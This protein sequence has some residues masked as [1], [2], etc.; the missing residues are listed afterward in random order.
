M[1]LGLAYCRRAVEAHGGTITAQ[2]Q[3]GRGTTF[4]IKIPAR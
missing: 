4:T 2:S 1:G 3:E